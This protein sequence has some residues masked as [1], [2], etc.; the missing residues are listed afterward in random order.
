MTAGHDGRDKSQ[1]WFCY[2]T[3][4][5]Q[6]TSLLARFFYSK[7]LKSKLKRADY[8]SLFSTAG[9]LEVITNPDKII[10]SVDVDL[11]CSLEP[12]SRSNY[13]VYLCLAAGGIGELNFRLN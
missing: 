4:Q 2:V 5:L 10:N 6:L 8:K 7:P 9:A 1:L 13:C 11:S 3:G 12:V